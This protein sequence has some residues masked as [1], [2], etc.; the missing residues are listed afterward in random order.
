[1]GMQ[2]GRTLFE[3]YHDSEFQTQHHKLNASGLGLDALKEAHAV[4]KG[5]IIVSDRFGHWEAMGTVI[6][7]QG[8]ESRAVY[9]Q[10]KNRHYE[11]RIRAGIEAGGNPILATGRVRTRALL[12]HLRDGGI[13]YY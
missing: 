12:R 3:I 5:A 2:M 6:K 11:R 7:M 8:L 4:C 9:K 13:I 1:M 10:N